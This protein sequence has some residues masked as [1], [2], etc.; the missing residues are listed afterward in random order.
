[1]SHKNFISAVSSYNKELFHSKAITWLLNQFPEFQKAF[2][3]SI[4]DKEEYI[5]ATFIEALSEIRQ[6]DIL[7]V[8][9][10]D[11]KYKFIHI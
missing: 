11:D 1:M 6:I 2:L 3:K 9:K 7:V 8:Y 5:K 10:L 4:L